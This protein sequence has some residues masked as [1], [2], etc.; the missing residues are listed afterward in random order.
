MLVI[1]LSL[2]RGIGMA[3]LPGVETINQYVE[4]HTQSQSAL[5]ICRARRANSEKGWRTRERRRNEKLQEATE[6][7][8]ALLSDGAMV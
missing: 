4:R 1:T 6:R 2:R 8:A 3:R 5:S 7:M